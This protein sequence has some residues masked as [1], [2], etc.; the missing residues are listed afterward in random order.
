[1]LFKS[2]QAVIAAFHEK[3]VKN[4]REEDPLTINVI[5]FGEIWNLE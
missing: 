1:M 5:K 3:D 4:K 2:G